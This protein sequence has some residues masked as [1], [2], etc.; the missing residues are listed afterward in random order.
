MAKKKVVGEIKGVLKKRKGSKFP[1]ESVAL[2]K[3]E[4]EDIVLPRKYRRPG[5]TSIGKVRVSG[6]YQRSMGDPSIQCG[7]TWW[8]LEYT[9]RETP[10]GV[11]G[12]I[13]PGKKIGGRGVSTWEK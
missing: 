8:I 3:R 5:E 6:R 13:L 12:T 7:N 9:Q 2:T 1:T 4:T 10:S 11:C